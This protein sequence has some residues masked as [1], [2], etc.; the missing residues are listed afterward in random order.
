MSAYRNRLLRHE[1]P[2]WGVSRPGSSLWAVLSAAG[3]ELDRLAFFLRWGFLSRLIE[4]CHVSLLAKHGATRKIPRYALDTDESY[5]NRLLNAWAFYRML[6]TNKAIVTMFGWLGYT[7]E[8]VCE[9]DW[10]PQPIT[11]WTEVPGLGS[12]STSGNVTTALPAETLATFHEGNWEGP[13]AWTEIPVAR[14]TSVVARMSAVTGDQNS[15][16]GIAVET[17]AG[18][19]R[20]AMYYV[21]DR[22]RLYLSL[23][24]TNWLYAQSAEFAFPED[25]TGWLKVEVRETDIYFYFGTGTEAD[26]PETWT[27]FWWGGGDTSDI[28]HVLF[29]Q[30]QIG[31]VAV[32]E[33]TATWSNVSSSGTAKPDNIDMWNRIWVRIWGYSIDAWNAENDDWNN[34]DDVWN[35]QYDNKVEQFRSIV[36]RCRACYNL[37]VGFIFVQEDGREVFM[38]F[39]DE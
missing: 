34:E 28:T 10:G 14:P 35:A 30:R 7:A 13:Y 38:I 29:F 2:S 6:G 9:K 12:V 8:V 15:N 27:E 11:G 4:T 31:D 26:E 3:D 33:T 19:R 32:T 1:L 24:D 16:F 36:L 37:F 23:L 5:R 25:G 20:Y 17:V 18:T 22:H 21:P 39:N